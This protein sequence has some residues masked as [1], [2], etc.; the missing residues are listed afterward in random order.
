MGLKAFRKLEPRP[1]VTL[2][3][4]PKAHRLEVDLFDDSS[5]ESDEAKAC[6]QMGGSGFS[7]RTETV[8]MILA[9][10]IFTLS[11]ALSVLFFRITL[12]WFDLS[13]WKHVFDG[14]RI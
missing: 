1:G 6:D 13:H 14:L 8:V 11:V 4:M 10:G 9:I 2:G 3:C 7:P 5:W 12:G